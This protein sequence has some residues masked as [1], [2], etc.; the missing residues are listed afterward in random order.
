[1]H[2]RLREGVEHFNA[3]RFWEAHESW[4]EL[5]LVAHGDERQYYQG[6]IQLAAAFHHMKRGT[7]RGGVRLFV[8]A[9]RRLERFPE[10][11]MEIARGDAMLAS[12]RARSWAEALIAAGETASM[13]PRNFPQLDICAPVLHELPEAPPRG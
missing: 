1:M 4:E 3:A 9:S 12:Q 7:L 6:L 13:D 11:H 2:P 5:W 8:A 10:C